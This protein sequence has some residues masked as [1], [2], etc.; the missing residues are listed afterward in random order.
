MLATSPQQDE[1][2]AKARLARLSKARRVKSAKAKAAR[3]AKVKEHR[4]ATG[5]SC[6]LKPGM[7][8][9]DLIVLGAGC[10]ANRHFICST[11]DLYR[12]LVGRPTTQ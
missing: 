1:Q 7:D 10:T 6:P 3:W 5:C 2:Q 12:S 9:H 8:W 11:L 4:R